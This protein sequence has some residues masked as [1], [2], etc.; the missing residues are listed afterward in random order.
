MPALGQR[1]RT[2][3]RDDA[4]L[5]PTKAPFSPLAWATIASL[6]ALVLSLWLILAGAQRTAR[7]EE[8]GE[9]LARLCLLE[10]LALTPLDWGD[11][12]MHEHL[13]AR[14][15]A[16]GLAEDV[17]VADLQ[18]GEPRD[19]PG[20]LFH[21][22]HY[23]IEVRPSPRREPDMPGD[24]GDL[25]LEAIATPRSA[26]SP[27]HT[28]FFVAE[29]AEPAFC[30]NLQYGYVDDD[31]ARRLAPGHAHRRVTSRFSE[32]AYRS[33]DDERWICKERPRR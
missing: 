1:N 33:F 26:A 8:R 28:A 30:R 32:W 11:V 25:P 3:E 31:P 2:R 20:F 27:S 21:N 5:L 17:F 22:K 19:L 15:I 4:G 7:A 9:G 29:D 6:L 14:V 10:A 16:R 12:G 24:H 23:T 18:A 13:L